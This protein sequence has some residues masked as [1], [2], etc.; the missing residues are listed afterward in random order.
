MLQVSYEQLNKSI[1]SDTPTV[2]DFF[3]EWCAPC[4]ALA[5]HLEKLSLERPSVSF[6]KVDVETNPEVQAAFGVSGLPT[7]IAFKGGKEV[8]RFAG[9]A[10]VQKVKELVDK[11]S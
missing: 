2:V 6:L 11:V 7:V 4:R 9:F 5:P 1:E 10:S 8:G 3:A